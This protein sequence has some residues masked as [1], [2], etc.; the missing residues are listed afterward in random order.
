M[1][2]A[3]IARPGLALSAERLRLPR[4]R[5]VLLRA[6]GAQDAA[7]TQA[8]VAGLSLDA[9]HKRFHVGLRQ[10]SPELLRQMTEVDQHQHVALVAQ[11]LWPLPAQPAPQLVADARYV[12]SPTHPDEAEFAIAVADDWQSLGLGRALMARLSGHARAQGLRALT[13]D[14]LV[15][16]RRMLVLMRGLGAGTRAHPDG[17]QLVRVVFELDALQALAR[18][19]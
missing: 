3:A 2:T 14:V 6:I 15:E 7:A 9:R 11:A 1:S 4:G 5:A 10:L 19:S 12:R 17:P 18:A 16:N 8:F 13:G